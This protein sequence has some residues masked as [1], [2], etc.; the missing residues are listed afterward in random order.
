MKIN[1]ATNISGDYL[2]T[3]GERAHTARRRSG[4]TLDAIS[5]ATGLTVIALS[6][7]ERGLCDRL[8]VA[9][10]YRRALHSLAGVQLSTADQRGGAW[11]K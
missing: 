5:Q 7:F 10:A 1:D 6:R 4:L 8:T 11:R 3:I 9:E 2:A